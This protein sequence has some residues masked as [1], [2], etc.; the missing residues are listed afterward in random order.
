MAVG[1]GSFKRRIGE[2]HASLHGQVIA[3]LREAILTG[4]LRG[5]D[6]LVEEKLA[7]ELGV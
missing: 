2:E 1:S 5:G 6:R 3:E 7:E 4:R